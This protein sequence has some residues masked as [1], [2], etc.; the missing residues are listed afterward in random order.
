MIFHHTTIVFAISSSLCL[1]PCCGWGGRQRGGWNVALRPSLVP[2]TLYA[3]ESERKRLRERD[4]EFGDQGFCAK[5]SSS[6]QRGWW[7]GE[8]EKEEGGESGR[9]EAEGRIGN[10]MPRVLDARLWRCAA[11]LS[12]LLCSPAT[13]SGTAPALPRPRLG[14]TYLAALTTCALGSEIRAAAGVPPH[15][16]PHECPSCLWRTRTP[17]AAGG[18]CWGRGWVQEYRVCVAAG[19]V[20]QCYRDA[21]ERGRCASRHTV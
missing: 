5:G 6:P 9:W 4:G 11:L 7:C 21:G 18:H 17:T 13:N 19:I 15:S 16:D 20:S 3:T 12:G 14:A 1:C 2:E 10:L 8:V